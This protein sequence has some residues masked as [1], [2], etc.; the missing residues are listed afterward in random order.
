MEKKLT[1]QELRTAREGLPEDLVIELSA[2]KK[3]AANERILEYAK[4]LHSK[5]GEET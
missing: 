2:D 4:R 5:D 1:L 3:P